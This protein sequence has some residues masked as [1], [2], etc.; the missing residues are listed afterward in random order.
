MSLEY[1]TIG[2]LD[3]LGESNTSDQIAVERE[4][5]TYKK[6]LQD[7]VDER[8]EDII[9]EY[10]ARIYNNGTI[11]ASVTLDDDDGN[12]IYI[13]TGAEI[14]IELPPAPTTGRKYKFI[15]SDG[16]IPMIDGN[17]HTINGLS[18]IYLISQ[19]NYLEII[20]DGTNWYALDYKITE[21]TGLINTSD[22]TNRHLGLSVV[23]VDGGA[24]PLGYLRGETV[25]ESVSGNTGKIIKF[26]DNLD[27]TGTL[28]LI[29]NTGG[30]VY[31]DGR[32]LTGG[33]SA[34]VTTI[35]EGGGTNKN[36]DQNVYHGMGIDSW[37]IK[38]RVLVS[39]DT[40]Y[41]NSR[42]ILQ[43]CFDWAASSDKN[44]GITV[45]Q[46]D[47]DNIKLQTGDA[48]IRMIIDDGTS[49]GWDTDNY[50]YEIILDFTL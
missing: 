6:N 36:Q 24:N 33:D 40:S 18:E 28:Y 8:A 16:K 49:D 43:I 42:E 19:Y 7:A 1:K 29:N 25:T 23:D 12:Y 14:D 3:S 30:G 35:N 26:D 46:I 45:F 10:S 20:F 21:R 48:G 15:T 5:I 39:T 31:T 50:Y 37:R 41:N 9:A 32:T 27:G 44:F 17:G 47:D 11:T 38:I 22:W 34:A 2:E 4:E 13:I